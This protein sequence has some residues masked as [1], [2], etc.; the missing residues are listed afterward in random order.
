[1]RNFDRNTGY[2]NSGPSS[3]SRNE[4]REDRGDRYY[5]D[6]RNRNLPNKVSKY[7]N[8][9]YNYRLTSKL[10]PLYPFF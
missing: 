4:R 10:Y 2:K 7:C 5:S 1:M 8:F 6:D 3:Y 9:K